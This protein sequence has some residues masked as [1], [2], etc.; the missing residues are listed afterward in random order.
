MN[1]MGGKTAL[2]WMRHLTSNVPPERQ[3][4]WPPRCMAAE[5]CGLAVGPEMRNG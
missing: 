5:K 3:V 2:D 1:Y 4:T